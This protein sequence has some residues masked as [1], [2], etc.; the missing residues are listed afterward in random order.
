MSA[1]RIRPFTEVVRENGIG[2]TTAYALVKDGKLKVC[3]VGHKTF[4]RDS[5]WNEFLASLPSATSP[6]LG[7]GRYLNRELRSRG[8]A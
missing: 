1:D 3:K 8:A 4:I 6:A 7:I 5:D 2:L